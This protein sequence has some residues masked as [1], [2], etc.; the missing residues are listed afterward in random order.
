M[1]SEPV[2]GEVV[3][4]GMGPDIPRSLRTIV[5]VDHYGD[6][7]EVTVQSDRAYGPEFKG[8]T[9][10]SFHRVMWTFVGLRRI[11]W[12]AHDPQRIKCLIVL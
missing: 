12:R 11:T 5:R 3:S 10:Q 2:I 7:V 4:L 1:I 6:H 8:F 9:D